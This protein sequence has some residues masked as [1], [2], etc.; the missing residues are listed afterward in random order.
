MIN[1]YS[2]NTFPTG[3]NQ[4]VGLGTGTSVLPPSSTLRLKVT[5]G[6]NGVSGVQITNITSTSSTVAGNNKALSVD[7]S[8]NIILTP[9]VNSNT[10]IIYLSS[11]TTLENAIDALNNPTLPIS[12]LVIDKSIN[13]TLNKT[14]NTTETLQ[15]WRGNVITINSGIRLTIN[16]SVEAGIFQIFNCGTSGITDG[17]PL[18]DQAYPQWWQTPNDNPTLSWSKSIQNAV[19]FYPKV[20]FPPRDSNKGY[21]ISET[22][23]LDL[24]RTN[25][26]SY[27]LYGAGRGSYFDTNLPLS[28]LNND[29]VF[30]CI[31]TPQYGYS[32]GI[33]FES[34]HFYCK[35]GIE[36]S[37]SSNFTDDF[38][39]I[40]RGSIN[41]CNFV[42]NI[43]PDFGV[44]IAISL[45]KAFDCKISNNLVKGFD[46]GI[47]LN[48]SDINNIS[49]NRITS[50]KLYGI[51]DLSQL[52]DA[53][54]GQFGSQN[55]IIHNDILG[56]SGVVNTGAFIKSNSLHIMIRD[57]FLENK[58]FVAK[59]LA[60]IDC[61]NIN[62]TN[63]NVP[64][65]VDIT[66]N[67]LSTGTNYSYLINEDFRSINLI[68]G[69]LGI[70]V[71]NIPPSSFVRNINTLTEIKDL[72]ITYGGRPRAINI[73][74]VFS[75]RDWNSFK[76]TNLTQT[77][78]NGSVL[79]NAS[80]VSDL[81]L[82]YGI[83]I[84]TFN[85]KHIK[86]KGGG[87]P[88]SYCKIQISQKSN[89]DI[90]EL[91]GLYRNLKFKLISRT[92]N[93]ATT[94]DDFYFTISEGIHATQNLWEGRGKYLSHNSSDPN[95]NNFNTYEFN[96]TIEFDSKKDYYLGIV[97]KY[98]TEIK[99]ISI[100]H[101][102]NVVKIDDGSI[103]E[104]GMLSF[105]VYLNNP[106]T[107]QI[108]LTFG[109]SNISTTNNDYSTATITKL[110]P[111]GVTQ[112]TIKIQTTNDTVVENDERFEISIIGSTGINGDISDTAIGTIINDDFSLRTTSKD[113]SEIEKTEILH[114][115]TINNELVIFPNP[116]QDI[117]KLDI[118]QTDILK[119]LELFD[120]S[121]KFIKDLTNLVND[122]SVDISSLPNGNYILKISIMTNTSKTII[123][124]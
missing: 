70:D 87:T 91:N 71:G 11:Y 42:E 40:L 103:T 118:K 49:D 97:S 63:L 6:S 53:T 80:N 31:N 67:R 89:G 122:N 44:N 43:G 92:T 108:S 62:L 114:K 25:N 21:A 2:Q 78:I 47:K 10:S 16:G 8:G 13:L 117:L 61:T 55:S 68:D 85:P 74:N 7:G 96:P 1:G 17:Y 100:E 72:N 84:P 119:N 29:F 22:I 56:Y 35:K 33:V 121:G 120:E 111:A 104:G 113:A 15:F 124:K 69:P 26:I 18:I 116:I 39:T 83:A 57:N 81:G 38:N 66:G 77:S 94:T 101:K 90:N 109:Y 102:F 3:T 52:T 19:N 105:P 51:L 60:Y 48:G 93:I 58:P 110:I 99:S 76:T 45:S 106:S 30:K 64:A 115:I 23:T 46:I 5:S 107:Q 50:F 95:Y 9:V 24:G 27:Y 20:Y 82:N 32:N 88:N 98:D 86:L 65:I 14:I 4:P 73:S 54:L 123:K 112:E 37:G 28:P 59:P 12:T 36:I 34:L 75:F 41:N 79:I